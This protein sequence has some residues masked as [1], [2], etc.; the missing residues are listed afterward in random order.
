[1]QERHVALHVVGSV[2]SARA[3]GT[4]AFQDQHLW[5][6]QRLDSAD[7]ARRQGDSQSLR[8]RLRGVGSSLVRV[9]AVAKL[10]FMFISRRRPGGA[11][12]VR[13]LVRT[14]TGIIVL[15]RFASTV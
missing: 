2:L 4:T 14:G 3:L 8:R 5:I 1:M 12:I 6:E 15:A 10:L 7:I 11:G 13:V 9:I